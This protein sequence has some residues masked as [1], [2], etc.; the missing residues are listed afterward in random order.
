MNDQSFERL[1]AACAPEWQEYCQHDFVRQLAEGTL[2]GE[3]FRHYL[4][5][6]YLFLVHFS[7]AWGLAVYKS[8]NLAE[9]RSALATLKAIVD[10]EIDLHVGYCREW[11]IDEADLQRLPE[12][13]P[14]IAYTRYVLDAGNRGELLDLH[15]ALAPC[16][17]GYAELAR[18]I[19][20]QPSTRIEGNP[21]AAW[22]E[23]YAGEGFQKAAADEVAWLDERL[24]TV[25]P[26]R[27]EAL[28]STFRDA[29]RLEADFWQ[30]GLDLK[31]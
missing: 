25:S 12:A 29:A 5:Q 15:V 9:I 11:G 22:I 1:K 20:G 31:N 24:K 8:V 10:F 17:I 4:K 26:R 30:M 27:F 7:R 3:A 6:D 19:M 14:T 23:V 18:W 16:L 13:R 2:P 21:Y 28:A